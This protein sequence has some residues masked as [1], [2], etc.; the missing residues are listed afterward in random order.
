MKKLRLRINRRKNMG[1]DSKI[2]KYLS[3]NDDIINEE[4]NK[5]KQK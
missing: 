1:I 3:K 2:G 5:S 4:I